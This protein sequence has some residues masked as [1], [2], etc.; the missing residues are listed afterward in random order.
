MGR[1]R[2][3]GL[4]PTDLQDRVL[5]WHEELLRITPRLLELPAA[6]R[7]A[8]Y[9]VVAGFMREDA[10]SADALRLVRAA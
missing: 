7:Q 2:H 8:L 5:D 6:A 3:D 10:G 1:S 9:D 4:V